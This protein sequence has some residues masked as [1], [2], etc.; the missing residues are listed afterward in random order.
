M[1]PFRIPAE[2]GQF[3]H[4]A[5]GRTLVE[6]AFGLVHNGGGG[7]SDATDVLQKDEPRTAIIGDACD[8]EEQAAAVPIEAGALAG[9]GQVLAWE[10]GND[11]IH[12]A[13]PAS[14][15]EGGNV[16]P[17]R[18]RIQAA[19]FHPRDQDCGCVSFPLN[20]ADGAIR[21]A[22]VFEPNSQS[23]AEHTDAGKQF[24]GR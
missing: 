16:G 21:E 7:R 6:F 10:S 19:F 1:H 18:C 22:Q 5:G 4:D 23:L 12:A 17:D 9:D 8:L 3:S 14:S 20:V 15:V 11:A 13:T 24:D 2:V